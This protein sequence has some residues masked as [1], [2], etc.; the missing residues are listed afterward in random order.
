MIKWKKSDKNIL[1]K[2]TKYLQVIVL[3][4]EADPT[5]ARRLIVII[6]FAH[7]VRSYA[8]P[9][10][11][12]FQKQNNCQAKTMFA[13]GETVCLAEW[14][15]DDTWLVI[16]VVRRTFYQSQPSRDSFF[17]Q[18]L[19]FFEFPQIKSV[20]FCTSKKAFKITL[21]DDKFLFSLFSHVCPSFRLPPLFNTKRNIK[22]WLRGPL[23]TLALLIHLTD[24]HTV[25]GRQNHCLCTCR[26]FIH[27][28]PLFRIKTKRKQCSL[29]VRLWV[30]PSGSLMTLVLFVLSFTFYTLHFKTCS[31][32]ICTITNLVLKLHI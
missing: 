16:I 4:H 1:I 14:I 31:F 11:P 6:V 7:V 22:F 10:V 23:A 18:R 21:N 3:I 32:I 5:V 19:S 26:P 15:I 28:S 25:T 17:M 12:T 9:S 29:L 13:T 30:W 24:P 20:I 27:L 2:T 8:R